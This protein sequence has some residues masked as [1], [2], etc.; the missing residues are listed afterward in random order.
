MPAS[1]MIAGTGEI[2]RVR[3]INNDMVATGPS[4]GRTPTN[5]PNNVPKKQ[6][7][8]LNGSKATWNP[9]RI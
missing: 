7:K 4:P 9:N 6:Q 8:R 5:V 2:L 1:I 3:G